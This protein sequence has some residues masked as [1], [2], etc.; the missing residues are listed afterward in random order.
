M[1]VLK[2]H[3]ADLDAVYVVSSI[4][5]S[6]Q[7]NLLAATEGHGQC[8]IFSPPDWHQSVVWD[9]PGGS[10]TL[11]G[12]PCQPNAFL[13]IQEFFPVFQSEGA[14]VV[15]A[16]LRDDGWN[17][18]RVFDLPFI[19]RFEVVPVE[20]RVFV[21]AASLCGGKDFRD[22]WSRPGALYVAEVP[23]DLSGQ[24]PLRE[25]KTG[26][27]RN[28]GMCRARLSGE[29]AILVTGAEGAFV[30]HPPKKLGEEWRVE[31]IM[32]HEVSEAVA[33]DLDGD[34][35]EEIATIEPFHGDKLG[36]YKKTASGYREVYSQAIAFGHALWAGKLLGR[37]GL[38]IGNRGGS[39]GLA[40]LT[41]AASDL[42]S[43]DS[44][45]IDSGVGPTQ[46]LVL[47]ETNQ[48]LSANHGAG[49]VALYT[50]SEK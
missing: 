32:S 31:Q 13:G 48:L 14:G 42:G 22:D 40:M 33:F 21:L 25:I 28:H 20:G 27:T 46:F 1:R 49:E 19:H 39:K 30:V 3:L 18:R 16:Q 44:A 38:L 6:G 26:I 47:P 10:M 5:I 23:H 7:R 24:W 35:V 2:Q 17:V 4:E 34:G 36:V 50:F 12:L 45:E 8:L 15:L 9:G 41:P 11:A 43:F 29:D 37:P